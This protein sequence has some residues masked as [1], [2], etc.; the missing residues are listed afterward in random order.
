M[1]NEHF[2]Q[3]MQRRQAKMSAISLKMIA[4]VVNYETYVPLVCFRP[5][6][7]VDLVTGYRMTL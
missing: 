5:L 4:G 3:C 7:S 1:N 6:Y 2:S